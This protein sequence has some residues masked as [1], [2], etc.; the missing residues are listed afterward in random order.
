MDLPPSLEAAFTEFVLFLPDLVTAVVVF[1]VTLYIA[2]VAN[3][4]VRKSLETRNIAEHVRILIGQVIRWG[5]IIFGTVTAL[6]QV[7]FDVTAFVAS[8]GI[9][10]F[11]LGFA[12]QDIAQNF[13]AGLVLLLQQPFSIGDMIEVESFQGKVTAIDLRATR[14]TTL[15][16]EDVLIPNGTVFT[17]PIINYTLTKA[18]RLKVEVGVAYD[19]DLE[20]VE[21]VALQAINSVDIVLDDPATRIAFHT[22]GDSSIVFSALFWVDGRKI[23]P[24]VAYHAV[25]IAIK[26]EFDAQGIEIPFPIR[27]LYMPNQANLSSS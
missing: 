8:L 9:V 7:D 2:G 19:S 16:G 23:N 15:D 25:V 3:R 10:G 27:T 20:H 5:V 22:F 11:A 21:R 13:I 6:Q 18:R 14:L 26:N 4:L 12:L 17:S 1:I 24:G